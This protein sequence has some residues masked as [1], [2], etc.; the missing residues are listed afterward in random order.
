MAEDFL[1]TRN[2]HTDTKAWF[3]SREGNTKHP[4]VSIDGTVRTLRPA[5]VFK[6]L[7]PA[8][9]SGGGADPLPDQ[10]VKRSCS[11]FL[12]IAKT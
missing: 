12:N 6:F 8:R 3:E 4:S 5:I 11:G 9:E 1:D 7:N 10:W 2:P